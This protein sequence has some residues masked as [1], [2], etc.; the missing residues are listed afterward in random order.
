MKPRTQTSAAQ[1]ARKQFSTRTADVPR[2][3]ERPQTPSTMGF[4]KEILVPT[5]FSKYSEGA[6]EYALDL[7]QAFEAKLTLVYVVEPPTF[8]DF[9]AMPLAVDEK[10]ITRAARDKLNNLREQQ[11]DD[12]SYIKDIKVVVGK[13]FE[14]ITS[15]ARGLRQ[16]LIVIATHGRTGLKHVLLGSTTEKVVRH[17]TCPVLVVRGTA[18]RK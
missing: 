13:P 8:T 9:Q 4:I 14:Q 17:A 12:A 10:A 6:L 7:A 11:G 5:D 15:L 2:T 16:N 3:K 18:S 1:R